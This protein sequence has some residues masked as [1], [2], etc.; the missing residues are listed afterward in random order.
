VASAATATIPPVL[1]Q[2]PQAHVPSATGEDVH[3]VE[4]PIDAVLL[5]PYVHLLRALA[6][7]APVAEQ[8]SELV[9]AALGVWARPGFETFMCEPRLRFEPFPHQLEAAARVLRHMQGRAILADEVGLGKTIE[10]GI[11]LCELR[12]RGLANRTLV[13]VP[14]GLVGQW[15]EEL[16]RKFA[17]PC[18]IADARFVAR[19]SAEPA[20][21][22][23]PV[24]I[25]SLATA[26]RERLA[27]QLAAVGWDLVIADEAH[28][29]KNA[30]SASA[31][32]ARSLRARYLLL[33]TATP[34]ENRLTDLFQLVNLVRPGLL[35]DAA[36]F[37]SRHGAGD[38]SAVRKRRLPAARAA[39]AA[40]PPPPQRDQRDAPAPT[41]GDAARDPHRTGSRP[42][43]GD[44]GAGARAGA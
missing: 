5:G 4:G 37:R 3:A 1:A 25:V 34:I 15:R 26:R 8:R 13:V 36:G 43:S 32:L 44:L 6:A 30:R 12:L 22:P 31:R 42:L 20:D 38:G 19:P 40:D 17:L 10:A 23:E 7:G 18:T 9:E 35:G 14:A 41:G 16:E 2:S 39:R 24:V 11:V 33:L 21:G 28:R 29:L 27:A